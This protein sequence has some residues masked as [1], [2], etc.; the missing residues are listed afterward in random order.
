[1]YTIDHRF[2]DA[3]CVIVPIECPDSV[4]TRSDVLPRDDSCE[5]LLRRALKP[6]PVKKDRSQDQQAKLVAREEALSK[7]EEDLN[8][9]DNILGKRET[10]FGRRETGRISSNLVKHLQDF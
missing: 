8:K 7:R 9:R 6:L 10:E 1:M 4:N 5:L 3:H 2:Q